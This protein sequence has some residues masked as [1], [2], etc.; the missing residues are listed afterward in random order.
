MGFVSVGA[1]ALYDEVEDEEEETVA[2]PPKK[3]GKKDPNSLPIFVHPILGQPITMPK[4]PDA[5]GGRINTTAIGTDTDK[6]IVEA[7][8]DSASQVPK[9]VGEGGH[10]YWMQKVLR[11]L[12][13]EVRAIDQFEMFQMPVDLSV[14]PDYRLLITRYVTYVLSA[15]IGLIHVPKRVI[16]K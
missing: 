12:L 6:G 9:C 4:I 2:A 11:A 3:N 13:R 1:M 7:S 10:L 16:R 8:M 5:I 14:V 15:S